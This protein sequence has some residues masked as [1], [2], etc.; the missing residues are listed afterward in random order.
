MLLKDRYHDEWSAKF[1]DV[2]K[3]TETR[4]IYGIADSHDEHVD[5][6]DTFLQIYRILSDFKLF[7]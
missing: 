5:H 6:I 2:W 7:I 1:Q 4:N 3:T